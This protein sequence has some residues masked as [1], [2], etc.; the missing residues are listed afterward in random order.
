LKRVEVVNIRDFPFRNNG[1]E[2]LI[3]DLLS[4]VQYNIVGEHN[5]VRHTDYVCASPQ[6]AAE[7]RRTASNNFN[8]WSA[9]PILIRIIVNEQERWFAASTHNA[10]HAPNM[11]HLRTPA[12]AGHTGHFC[13]WVRE[14][15]TGSTSASYIRDMR[16]AVETAATLGQR[17]LD[18]NINNPTEEVEEEMTQEKFNAMYAEMV[19]QMGELPPRGLSPTEF[20]AAIA[21]GLTDG[22]RPQ[23]PLTLERG[24]IIAKRAVQS[25]VRQIR[26]EILQGAQDRIGSSNEHSV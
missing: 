12:Q 11:G 21:L 15:Q 9:R 5:N 22:T 14:A 7:K 13:L 3:V 19:R 23:E 1:E 20:D 25:A 17:W 24:A 2:R 26:D 4:G 8:D 10:A 18:E 6:D 16:A